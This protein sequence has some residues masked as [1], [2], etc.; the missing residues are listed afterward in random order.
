MAGDNVSE[1]IPTQVQ[2]DFLSDGS[3]RPRQFTYG[4]RTLDVIYTGRQ[5]IDSHSRHVLVMTSAHDTFELIVVMPE[6][7]WSVV[8]INKPTF[9]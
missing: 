5:W 8:R 9:V 3:V 6:M 2:A 7:H 1:V 4:D